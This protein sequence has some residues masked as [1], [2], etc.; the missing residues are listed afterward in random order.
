MAVNIFE[1]YS[2]KKHNTF[3]IE[4]K[5]RYFAEYSSVEE[6][7]CIARMLREGR[8]PHPVLHIGEGSNLLFVNN[9]NGTV[10]HSSIKTVEVQDTETKTEILSQNIFQNIGKAIDADESASQCTATDCKH[11]GNSSDKV[12]VRVGSGVVW[13]D[14]VAL[15]VEKGWYGTENLSG[16][17]GEVGASAVQNIGA[18]GAE[19]KDIIEQVECYD[20][21]TGRNVVFKVD[22]CGYGYRNSI[23][24]QTCNKKYIVTHVTFGLSSTP[25]WN[26]TYKALAD[27]LTVRMAAKSDTCSD[28]PVRST[29]R[30]TVSTSGHS[31]SATC[32][33]LTETVAG[34]IAPK[35]FDTSA[36]TLSDVRNT[37]I[38]IR[39]SKLPDPKEIGSAGSFFTNPIV[40]AAK[41]EKLKKLHPDMPV[42]P[43]GK[44]TVKLSAGWLIEKCGWKGKSMG[45][46]GVYSKQALVLV[47][48]GGATGAEVMAIAEAVMA[49]VRTRFDIRL[50]PEANIIL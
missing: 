45:H 20:L 41:A 15:C 44:G 23:F 37:I 42:Y 26:L 10:L 46:A 8:L 9:F 6:L 47:N 21:E 13:D 18:Y 11:Q 17:P 1:N 5:A 14:F 43:A 38:G 3:G 49:T 4:A 12:T 35:P 16:I 29:L 27:A 7:E 19:V 25:V 22:E 40:P 24:K 48:L 36:L 31:C 34:N 30:T 39:D 2:L 32:D 33:T 50:S 28:K